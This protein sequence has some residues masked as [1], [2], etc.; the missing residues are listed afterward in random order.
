MLPVANVSWF[1]RG[2]SSSLVIGLG[3]GVGGTATWRAG[4][5]AGTTGVIMRTITN[6]ILAMLS[7]WSANSTVRPKVLCT[8]GSSR[9]SGGMFIVITASSFR[10]DSGRV[11]VEDTSS[12][13]R[14][15]CATRHGS[16]W[17]CLF[18]VLKFFSD[19]SAM[20][21]WASFRFGGPLAMKDELVSTTVSL[22]LA[23]SPSSLIAVPPFMAVARPFT[24][25]FSSIGFSRWAGTPAPRVVTR[26]VVVAVFLGGGYGGSLV[27]V[28]FA[29][30]ALCLVCIV[31]ARFCAGGAVVCCGTVGDGLWVI[32]LWWFI[33]EVRCF[34]MV[35]VDTFMGLCGVQ[36]IVVIYVRGFGGLVG[37]G[38]SIWQRGA[39]ASG[40]VIAC[41][42]VLCVEWGF[43]YRIR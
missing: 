26:G 3:M 13:R 6:T 32:V 16:I 31:G 23:I 17:R 41:I 8:V 15:V 12:T 7:T 20:D 22:L 19:S 33:M 2:S 24:V 1:R 27:R 9:V 14:R 10:M 34:T 21:L 39:I 36:A 29:M 30:R 38:A 5:P 40:Q 18:L 28:L 4:T 37:F 42:A 25:G 11:S 43:H 35:F